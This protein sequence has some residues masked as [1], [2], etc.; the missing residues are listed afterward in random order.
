MVR[1]ARLDQ[2]VRMVA[3]D[4]SVN[5]VLLVPQELQEALD[6]RAVWVSRVNVVK[7]DTLGLL[8][9]REPLDRKE[10]SDLPVNRV[11]L[12]P[13]VWPDQMDL[14]DHQVNPAKR[15]RRVMSA[16]R[17]S[18]EHREHLDHQDLKVSRVKL[19]QL[20]SLVTLEAPEV[21]E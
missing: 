4:Q 9:R 2:E 17:V 5:P 14:R 12:E 15:E 20:A 7:L 13:K 3:L 8:G 1:L 6:Q 11:R 10:K 18:Q 16:S 19:V 21:Q